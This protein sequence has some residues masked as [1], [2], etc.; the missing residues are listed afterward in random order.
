[1]INLSGRKITHLE[2]VSSIIEKKLPNIKVSECKII[3]LSN[4]L[5][6]KVDLSLIPAHIKY[7]NLS[8]NKINEIKF[9]NVEREEILLSDN[10]LKTLHIDGVNIKSLD[11]STNKLEY[12]KFSSSS[13]DFVDLLTNERYIL[14]HSCKARQ[15]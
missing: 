2:D 9:D 5:I 11:I 8:Y 14:L 3:D 7:I 4:N 1:M 12:I 15:W 13:F 6:E 10:E